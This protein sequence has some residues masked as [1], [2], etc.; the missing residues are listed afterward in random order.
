MYILKNICIWL[1]KNNST[2][3]TAPIEAVEL[4]ILHKKHT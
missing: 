3:S 4:I 2:I 1:K